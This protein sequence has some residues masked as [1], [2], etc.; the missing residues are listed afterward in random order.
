MGRGLVLHLL[1]LCSG[2]E[3]RQVGANFTLGKGLH[4]MMQAD[5]LPSRHSPHHSFGNRALIFIDISAAAS[6]ERPF[7]TSSMR[8]SSSKVLNSP[9]AP[10]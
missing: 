8:P 6:T 4:R 1:H 3:L 7:S 9:L 2:H 5:S 10:L